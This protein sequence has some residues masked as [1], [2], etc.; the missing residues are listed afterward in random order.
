[1]RN[2]KSLREYI[3]ALRAIGEVQPIAREVDWNL[4]SQSPNILVRAGWSKDS[5]KPGDKALVVIHPL[6]DG[7]NG[8]SVFRLTI[9]G[10]PLAMGGPSS[11]PPPTEP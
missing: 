1:M 5:I 8:G 6:K 4:E 7:S 10:H 2:I 3:E 9:N 11:A